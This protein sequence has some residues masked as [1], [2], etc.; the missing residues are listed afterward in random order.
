MSRD[1]LLYDLFQCSCMRISD[2]S[3]TDFDRD[4]FV[5]KAGHF[6]RGPISRY[7]EPCLSVQSEHAKNCLI[8]VGIESATF[9]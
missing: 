1:E 9:G 2:R 5:I 8:V 6:D 4:K 7:F 3:R